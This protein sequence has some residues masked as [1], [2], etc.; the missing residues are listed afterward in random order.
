MT[1]SPA[2]KPLVPRLDDAADRSAVDHLADLERP[3]V[4]AD[5]RHAAAHVRVDRDEDVADGDLAVGRLARRR[6]AQLEVRLLRLALRTCRE[7]DLARHAG[8]SPSP[9]AS[10]FGGSEP[11]PSS[12]FSF[13][14]S[15]STWLALRDL[16]QLAVDVVA[17]RGEV[18]ERAGRGQLVDRV[19]A[20]LQLLASC[21]SRAGPRAPTSAICS[22]IPVAASPIRTCASAA[23]YCA[24]ITS[25]CVRNDSTFVCSALLALDQLLLL[26]LELL[27][28]LHDPLRAGPRSPPCG[29]APRARDPRGSPSAPC[30]PGRRACRP[31][32]ASTCTASRAASSP[33]ST[34]AMPRL[35]FWSWRSCSS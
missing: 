17:G 23:E 10:S 22:P 33:S 4:R 34:S 12:A 3:D 1:Q 19:G 27:A 31:A 24:L 32:A 16:L 28:L 7:D 35:T 29:S 8:L 11:W 6:V 25:F 20:R 26:R 21:P 2:A 30:A 14:S 9:P 18:L 15:S 13:A 5:A